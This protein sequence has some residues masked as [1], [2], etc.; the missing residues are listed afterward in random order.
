MC[1]QVYESS[2]PAPQRYTQTSS[3]VSSSSSLMEDAAPQK[4]VM[5]IVGSVVL[6]KLLFSISA[7]TTAIVGI[8]LALIPAHLHVY[9]LGLVQE[10]LLHQGASVGE[11]RKRVKRCLLCGISTPLT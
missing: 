9:L 4:L 3:G 2:N 1:F 11:K 10:A 6:R 8:P 7:I 5:I